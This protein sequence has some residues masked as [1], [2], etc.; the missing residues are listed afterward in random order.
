MTVDAASP[1]PPRH[2]LRAVAGRA[3]ERVLRRGVALDP[4]LREALGGL[5]GRRVQLRLSAPELHFEVRV[6]SGDLRVG[7]PREAPDLHVAATPMALLG[8]ALGE[9]RQGGAAPGKVEIAGDAELAQRLQRLMAAW[10]PDIEAA[11]AE[12]LG[13]V[14]GVPLARGL[15]ALAQGLRRFGREAAED[16]ADWLREEARLTPARDELD[17]WLD[18]VDALRERVDRLDARLKRLE[19][20]A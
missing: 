4:A 3:L 20:S 1:S 5:E 6:E 12:R 19:S 2:P 14:T 11:L 16:G 17:E 8:M 7:P 10:S 9:R 18:A 13:D 15:Q